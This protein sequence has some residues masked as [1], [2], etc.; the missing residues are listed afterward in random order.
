VRYTLDDGP[1]RHL[2]H[3][4]Y[5]G[6]TISRQSF[7]TQFV[8]DVSSALETSPCRLHITGVSPEE[9]EQYW[10]SESV[11]ITFRLFPVDSTL[12]SALTKLIQE[13]NS[14][15][16]LVPLTDFMD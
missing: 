9:S 5:F 16:S 15:L 2:M 7:E 1:G 13:S 14:A 3:Q 4:K 6:N 12:I 10:D 8:L 11:F